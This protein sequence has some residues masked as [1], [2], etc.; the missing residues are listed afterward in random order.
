MILALL[1]MISQ[2]QADWFRVQSS[3]PVRNRTNLFV[4]TYMNRG[5]IEAHIPQ[6]T[7]PFYLTIA[8]DLTQSSPIIFYKTSACSECS[9]AAHLEAEE[10]ITTRSHFQHG[11]VATRSPRRSPTSSRNP[12][13]PYDRYQGVFLGDPSLGYDELFGAHDDD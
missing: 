13:A 8:F 9:N 3:T 7:L 11:Q 6:S 10:H 1:F 5:P 2:A 12:V 4:A